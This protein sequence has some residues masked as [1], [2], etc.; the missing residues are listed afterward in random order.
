M[1]AGAMVRKGA[2]RDQRWFKAYEDWNVATGLACGFAGK[3]QIGKGMW[4]A[5]DRMADML[6][7]K[8]AHTD[9]RRQRRLGAL[10]H[11]RGA[12]RPALPPGSTWRPASA[13]Y[14]TARRHRATS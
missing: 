12:A 3:A 14:P 8:A 13:P 7:T 5:P 10:A 4:A 6:A 11:R 1:R 9:G 2:M